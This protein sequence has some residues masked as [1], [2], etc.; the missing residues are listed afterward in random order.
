MRKGWS[1]SQ[2]GHGGNNCFHR[3]RFQPF[4]AYS[5]IIKDLNF[6]YM[7]VIL[8]FIKHLYQFT[9]KPFQEI[10]G[11][12]MKNNFH[13]FFPRFKCWSAVAKL[14]LSLNLYPPHEFE[15]RFVRQLVINPFLG[16]IL[17]YSFNKLLT[18]SME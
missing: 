8:T 9:K 6:Y 4:L 15:F 2:L 7:P 3:V 16:S 5:L 12:I 18:V 10:T 14:S 1:F 11:T 17:F 13:K